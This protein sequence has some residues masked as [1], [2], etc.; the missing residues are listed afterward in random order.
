MSSTNDEDPFL[1]VQRD[2]LDQ[3]ASTRSI[4]TSF[5]RIRSLAASDTSP[6]LSSARSDLESA[7]SSLSDDLDDLKASVEA[8]ESNPSQFGLSQDEVARR[9]RLVD[10]IGGE[11][12]DMRDELRKQGGGASGGG[13]KAAGGAGG[14]NDL[15]DP[16]S[17]AVQ[18][19]YDPYG[20]FE[21]QQQQQIMREQDAQLDGVSTTVGN[22]RRQADDMGREL[23]EQREMLEVVDQAADRV[24]GRL[25]TGVE[26]LNH[27]VRK[28]EDTLSSYCIGLLI[29]ALIVLLV[30]LLML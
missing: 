3:I 30:L 18:D 22:L 6:E 29:F 5:L 24:G 20:E 7:L 28:N 4:F 19:D 13:G 8:V 9:K 11:T 10:E 2:V 1:E 14:G 25:Q 21:Q 16:N 17:F 27:I 12:E 26:R 15:P 23:E